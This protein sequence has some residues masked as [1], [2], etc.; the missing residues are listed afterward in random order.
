MCPLNRQSIKPQC[1]M[2]ASRFHSDISPRH[3]SRG[4]LVVSIIGSFKCI[5]MMPMLFREAS[6]TFQI[7][8][9]GTFA[10]PAGTSVVSCTPFWVV[11][12]EL[13]IEVVVQ[14]HFPIGGSDPLALGLH[15]APSA[16]HKDNSFSGCTLFEAVL[17]EPLHSLSHC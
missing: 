10:T 17:A 3:K 12:S 9:L 13:R 2:V 16:K 5:R 11:G 7:H 15:F 14:L 8:F 4:P 6:G 1:F